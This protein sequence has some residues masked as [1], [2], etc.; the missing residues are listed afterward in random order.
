MLN[1]GIGLS[2]A[3][4]MMAWREI[5]A[6]VMEGFESQENVRPA[7][8]VN[9]A[10]RRRLKLDLLYPEAGLAV[11]FVGLSARGQPRK[12]DWDL[13]EEEQ[14]EQTRAHLCRL[15]GVELFL[16]DVN[17]PEPRRQLQQ[18]RT[19]LS[20]LARQAAQSQRSHAEKV[21]LMPR[22]AEARKR[23][24]AVKRQLRRP[25]DLALFAELW[26]DRE[27][28]AVATTRQPARPGTRP[29]TAQQSFR[30]GQVVHHVRFG[31]GI[32][33]A[34]NGTRADPQIVVEFEDGRQRTF[35][36]SLVADK[37]TTA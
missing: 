25:D 2:N 9:P 6:R 29:P 22:L 10:T 14:R 15:N 21:E 28:A 17:H 19:L 12:N 3:L 32:V 36:A 11:R 13:L 35:L 8:L 30:P 37:M 4:T 24:D 18:L 31:T 23:L 33:L 34:L 7:W 27:T 5:M 16:L 1:G 20:R 26:R